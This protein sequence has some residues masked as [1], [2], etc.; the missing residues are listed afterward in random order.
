[1]PTAR[2]MFAAMDYANLFAAIVN[3]TD[4]A[5]VSKN[6]DGTILTWN[7]AAERIFGWTAAEM[8]GQSI[9]K[10]IPADL[11]G[12]EDRI[13][14]AVRRG[15]R[16]LQFETERVRKDGQRIHIAVLV[17][18]VLD[19]AGQVVGASKIARDITG[20]VRVRRALAEVEMRFALMADN[21]AQLAWIA[22]PEGRISWYNKRWFEYTGVSAEDMANDGWR[23][24]HHPNHLERVVN[25]AAAC[26]RA[27]EEWEDTFPLRGADGQYR[28]FLTRAVPLRNSGGEIVCW[29]G[30]NT[31]ITE[32]RAAER[33][34]E[35]LL[36]EVNH[37]SRNLLTVVQSLAE[38]TAAED[39]AEFLP[40]LRQRIAGLAANQDVLVRR[41]WREVPLVELVDAQLE[42]LEQR[43]TQV[44]RSGPDLVIQARAAES[45]SMALHELATNAEK[46]GALSV[47]GGRVTIG[48]AVEPD[49]Q[50]GQFRL[51]WTESGGPPVT[52]PTRRGFGRRIIEDVPARKLRGTVDCRFDPAGFRFTLTCPADHVVEV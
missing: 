28:W 36:M 45:V 4:A 41:N 18:P 39:G 7:P 24:L 38:R 6:L 52:P 15:E 37:R 48:W 14:A 2:D 17:S 21:I 31:D 11:Q 49:E 30:T 33:Q 29:F 34:I 20:E 46:Y 19:R 26:M 35:L 12:E 3:S 42:F 8:I 44:E 5:V 1:M 16:S 23:S 40:R 25:H 43:R 13:L 32:Q 51:T 9:R 22:D 10:L 50:G 27:G 47:P